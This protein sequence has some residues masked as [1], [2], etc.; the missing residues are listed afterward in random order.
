VKMRGS[1]QLCSATNRDGSA[2]HGM[3]LADGFCFSHS[4]AL[5]EKRMAARSKGGQHSAKSARLQKMM[6]PR[7]VPVFLLLETVLKE[8]YDR[9]IDART[10]QAIASVSRSLV[11]V[12]TAGELEE[13]VRALEKG[14]K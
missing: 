13:R 8:L 10:A 4:P 3:A 7:L 6:P 12:F 5:R 9:Q 14:R 1:K 2:C 11:F